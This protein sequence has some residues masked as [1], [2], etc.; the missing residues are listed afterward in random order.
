M[1]LQRVCVHE[2]GHFYLAYKYRPERAV[3]IRI[4]R[5]VNTDAPTGQEYVSAG[6]VITFEP[7][8]SLPRVQVSIRAAGLAA[9]SLIYGES[10][11]DLMK[12]PSVQW[13]VKTDKDNAKRDLEMAG[14]FPSSEAEFTWF[15]WR[16]GFSDAVSMM[17]ASADKLSCIAH[18]C[19]AN[20][21]RDIPKAELVS[22]CHL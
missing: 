18:Y 20:L 5:Q 22:A 13:R 4:S 1:D 21:D 8:G 14:L 15:Y 11:D 3:S 12:S 19:L 9:E 2:A 10:F 6:T 16:A 17:E 7:E